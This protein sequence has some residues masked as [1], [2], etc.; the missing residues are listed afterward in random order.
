MATFH[1]R[2]TGQ[3]LEIHGGGYFTKP[4]TAATLPTMARKSSEPVDTRSPG[5]LRPTTPDPRATRA[6]AAPVTAAAR[7]PDPFRRTA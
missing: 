1:D 5:S 6:V 4:K 3:H 7:K 2:R